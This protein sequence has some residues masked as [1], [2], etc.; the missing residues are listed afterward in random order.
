MGDINLYENLYMYRQ[1]DYDTGISILDILNPY[2]RIEIQNVIRCIENAELFCEDL[3]QDATVAMYQAFD[4]YRDDMNCTLRS[5]VMTIARRKIVQN[6]KYYA[7]PKYDE[8]GYATGENWL[9]MDSIDAGYCS[10]P[11]QNRLAEP[12]Y[13]TRFYAAKEAAQKAINELSEK[14]LA[15]FDACTGKDTYLENCQRLDMSY[16]TYDGKVQRVKKKVRNAINKLDAL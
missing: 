5:F 13:Y 11:Q 16:K 15:V 4:Y 8:E 6:A 9:I 14:E 3:M 7:F 2:I 12:E 10:I 1:G